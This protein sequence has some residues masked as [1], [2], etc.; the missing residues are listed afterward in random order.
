MIEPDPSIPTKLEN[1]VLTITMSRPARLNAVDPDTLRQLG[2]VLRSACADESTRVI[3]LVGAGRAFCTGADLTSLNEPPAAIMDA[4]N[5]VIRTIVGAPVPVIAAVNG[6]AAGFGAS[7]AC[8]ADLAFAAQSAYFL[9]PFTS[10][11]LM[12]DGGATRLV[13]AAIG[14]TR[15]AE[16]AL[17]GERVPAADAVK[18][19]LVSR[20][21]PD[22][23]LAT[24]VEAVARRLADRPRRALELTKKALAESALGAFDDVLERE[25]DGQIELLGTPD[26]ERRVAAVL[27]T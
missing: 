26:F 24:Y 7:L 19:G 1:A 3:V 11:G 27:R 14:R 22:D 2:A 17:L 15:A 4:A 23:A 12:P 21:L 5:E 16:M 13:S 6:P 25:R 18:I 9:L 8:V 10:I 20:V